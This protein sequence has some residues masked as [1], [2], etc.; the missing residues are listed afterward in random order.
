MQSARLLRCVVVAVAIVLHVAAHVS[1]FSPSLR[2][3][4]PDDRPALLANRSL[5]PETEAPLSDAIGSAL[6]DPAAA[7]D[8]GGEIV[9]RSRF[10]PVAMSLFAVERSVGGTHAGALAGLV[11]LLLHVIVALGAAG[12]AREVSGSVRAGWLAGLFAVSA[13]VA[14]A[15]AAWPARQPLVLAAALG[16]VGIRLALGS[17]LHRLLASGCL[18]AL[19]GL[20]HELG[21]GAA[22]AALVLVGSGHATGRGADGVAGGVVARLRPAA[23]IA[24]PVI[25]A[26]AGR[27]AVLSAWTEV[28]DVGVGATV[29]R[30][31]LFDAVAGTVLTLIAPLLPTRFHLAGGPWLATPVARIASALILITAGIM[32]ARR[33]RRP[34]AALWLAALAAAT[35]AIFSASAGG[36]P[37]HDGYAYVVLPVLAASVG[38]SIAAG[39]RAGGAVR[40]PAIA[41][42]ALLVGASVA[43]TLTASPSFR[44]STAFV[45]VAYRGD[46]DS[47]V[48]ACWRLGN[49]LSAIP[50]PA[51]GGTSPAEIAAAARVRADALLALLPDALRVANR[52]VAPEKPGRMELEPTAEG[53]RLARDGAAALSV[54]SVLS[55]YASSVAALPPASVSEDAD[56]LLPEVVRVAEAAAVVAPEWSAAWLWLAHARTRVGASGAALVA[57]R[58]AVRLA[59]NDVERAEFLARLALSVGRTSLAVSQMERVALLEEAAAEQRGTALRRDHVLLRAQALSADASTRGVL[60]EF[61]WAARLLQPLWDA[62]DRERDLRTLLY[63]LYTR[64]GDTLASLDKAAMARLAYTRA[65]G[66]GGTGSDAAEHLGW[67]MKRIR[68]ERDAAQSELR[69]ALAGEGNVANALLNVAIVL[70]RSADWD[71]ADEL[72]AK[73]AREQGGMNAPLRLAIAVHRHAAR[74]DELDLAE[75]ELRRVL[76]EDPDLVTARFELAG[77]LLQDGRLGEAED[78]YRRAA[79]DGAA[80]EWSVEALEFARHLEDL[81]RLRSR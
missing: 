68:R 75:A 33:R 69:R 29:A 79:R 2:E 81:R 40:L 66:L 12:L 58:E 61:D 80:Y 73:I 26:I 6:T 4:L 15:T 50:A 11:S 45:D 1:P 13:P 5:S 16:I 67:L 48:V 56:G 49:A 34:V 57:A 7:W 54:A 3:S 64:W 39:V 44:S 25:A 27:A 23:L 77:V 70:C 47:L 18:L 35:P 30:P 9:G 76:G 53:R 78:E 38:A 71:G 14:L 63:E 43:T 24:L 72:F 46:R 55:A 28:P 8:P 36:T 52:L 19:A 32:L 62:G 37:F 22:A 31:D 21:Y 10:R 17:G 59:P 60:V 41:T 65:V 51:A 42:G 74:D 20:S